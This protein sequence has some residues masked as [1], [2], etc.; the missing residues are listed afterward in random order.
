MT[1]HI[2]LFISFALGFAGSVYLIKRHIEL[3]EKLEGT[4]EYI[5]VFE[6]ILTAVFGIFGCVIFL[7]SIGVAGYLLVLDLGWV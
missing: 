6:Y 3:N 4:Y 5:N 7:P 1:L 2:I